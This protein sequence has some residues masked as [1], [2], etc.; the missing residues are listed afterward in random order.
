MWHDHFD[1]QGK[2]RGQAEAGVVRI[3]GE[4]PELGRNFSRSNN[5]GITARHIPFSRATEACS[6]AL[7]FAT[8]TGWSLKVIC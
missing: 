2:Q 6:N 7:S 8:D 4:E 1:K 5:R 3:A